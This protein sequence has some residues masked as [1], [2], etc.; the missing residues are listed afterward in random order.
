M[1]F[2]LDRGTTSPAPFDG[3]V[4]HAPLINYV[5]DNPTI[6]DAFTGS[7]LTHGLSIGAERVQYDILNPPG[8]THMPLSPDAANLA[9]ISIDIPH[10]LTLIGASAATGYT[11]ETGTAGSFGGQ[12]FA[13]L[14]DAGLGTYSY[15]SGNVW[16]IT[17]SADSVTFFT[18][19]SSFLPTSAAT[20]G[21]DVNGTSFLQPTFSLLFAT[22]T[23]LG[24]QGATL[25]G[26]RDAITGTGQLRIDTGQTESAVPAVPEPSSMAM[27]LFAAL[28][29]PLLVWTTRRRAGG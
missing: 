17:Y 19:G 10:G 23:P 25:T 1:A 26:L 4:A 7:G 24:L 12:A 11:T 14:F 16:Q 21:V 5:V 8:N 20:G 18:D 29:L 3:S 28:V 9:A 15:N 6:T 2:I 22:G 27:L 13:T